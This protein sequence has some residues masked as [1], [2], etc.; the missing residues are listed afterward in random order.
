[1]KKA[2]LIAAFAALSLSASAIDY[3]MVGDNVDGYKWECAVPE[4]KFEAQGDGVF[5]WKGK[6]LGTGFKINDG[7]WDYELA[8]PGGAKLTV[9]EDFWYSEG[10]DN[11][12]FTDCTLVKDPVVTLNTVEG[13]LKVDGTKVGQVA[14]YFTGTFNDYFLDLEMTEIEAGVFQVKNVALPESGEFKVTTTGWGEQ[15]GSPTEAPA[16]ITPESLTAVLGVVGSTN[17]CPFTLQPGSYDITWNYATTTVTFTVVSLDP[18]PDPDPEYPYLVADQFVNATKPA[19]GDVYDVLLMQTSAIAALQES[20]ATVNNL[21]KNDDTRFF[22]VWVN[23]LAEADRTADG[24]GFD[25]FVS[26]DWYLCMDVTDAGWSG[27]SFNFSKDEKVN[28]NENTRLRFS[29]R[30]NG[31]TP[32]SVGIKIADTDSDNTSANIALGADFND[33]GNIYKAIGPRATSDWQTID[34]SFADLKKLDPGFSFDYTEFKGNIFSFL[35]GGVQGT[36]ICFD[37]IY[38]YTPA[39]AT[40]DPVPDP[41]PGI[42]YYLI[43]SDVNGKSWELAATDAKFTYNGDGTYVWT[44]EHLGTGFKINDGTWDNLDVNFGSEG[45]DATLL[46]LDTD[47]VYTVGMS[48]GNIAF[49]GFTSVENPTVVLDPVNK[50]IRISGEPSGLICW[51]FTGD[52]NDWSF[53]YEMTE[54]A[55]NVFEVKNVTLPEA[56]EFKIA[57]TGWADQYGSRLDNPVEISDENLA[58]V[59]AQVGVNNAC[60]F[61]LT[62][63]AYDIVWDFANTTVTFK[64]ASVGPDPDPDHVSL[65]VVTLNGMGISSQ[66][67]KGTAATVNFGIDSYW[68]VES[69]T[70]NGADV[71][72][73]IIGSSFT[74]PKL[75]ADAEV[76]VSVTYDGVLITDNPTGV[77]EVSGSEVTV[78]VAESSVLIKG[79]KAGDEV[80]VYD[81]TGRVIAAQNVS[82]DVLEIRLENNNCYIIR[83]NDEA[84]K[85]KL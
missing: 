39:S 15:Y 57:Q 53:D 68:K 18:T 51:Y 63:G 47:Y 55:V 70:F 16:E 36:N 43:G 67:A 1:M 24:I 30:S 81:L 14:W 19:K 75:E 7:T 35:A 26:D 66:V 9:G 48:I 28:W 25:G 34:I 10:G 79:L 77:T 49:D 56:G 64:A 44:G 74:T 42:D 60:P 23:T 4:T 29:Y 27:A 31:P 3:Y 78:N 83:I 17:A 2:L 37:A 12:A 38:F 50:T 82:K 20:G 71:T 8:A 59:L 62:P 61:T 76:E 11:I 84:V 52:F 72:S 5:V 65:K 73:D 85:V 13:T 40:P 46:A 22:Y 6:E 54:I 69:L 45:I 21:E 32:E 58:A 41:T 80:M 33:N